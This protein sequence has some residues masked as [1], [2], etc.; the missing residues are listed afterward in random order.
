MSL[1]LDDHDVM[2]LHWGT[3]RLSFT[4]LVFYFTAKYWSV[5]LTWSLRPSGLSKRHPSLQLTM[6][7]GD[8]S[9]MCHFELSWVWLS[10]LVYFLNKPPGGS[11]GQVNSA[12]ALNLACR[13]D[14]AVFSTFKR[15]FHLQR[16][17]WPCFIISNNSRV[18]GWDRTGVFVAEIHPTHRCQP[19]LPLIC[20]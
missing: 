5:L 19:F 18:R 8:N 7:H 12:Y 20:Y 11:V 17:L 10:L 14:K 1:P 6:S 16:K 15:Q 2:I 13:W 3:H 9:D 4:S